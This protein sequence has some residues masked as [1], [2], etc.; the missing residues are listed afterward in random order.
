MICFITAADT[1]AVRQ[2]V[3]RNGAPITNCMFAGDD[4]PTTFHLGFFI[5]QKIVGIVSVF[6]VNNSHFDVKQ[7]WQLRGMAVLPTFQHQQIGYQLVRY[8]ENHLVT[9]QKEVFVWMNARENAIPFY[10][11][12]GY[13][14]Y[15]SF[16]DIP[17]VGTHQ[18]MV[19]TMV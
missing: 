11:K 18:M 6:K 19:K 3:L 5:H 2:E 8:A 14:T 1:Y 10:L 16:F 15:G 4:D 12:L 13:T 7:Q 17:T 9:L